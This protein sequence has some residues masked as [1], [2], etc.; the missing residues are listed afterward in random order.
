MADLTP[1]QIDG[2]Q[3][4]WVWVETTTDIYMN[5][6]KAGR[7]LWFR[8]NWCNADAI[9]LVIRLSRLTDRRYEDFACD[10]HLAEWRQAEQVVPRPIQ[11]AFWDLA[12]MEEEAYYEKHKGD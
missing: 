3:R 10:H 8:C 1:Q 2:I 12:A 11:L 6:N 4:N 5:Y 9:G 7:P